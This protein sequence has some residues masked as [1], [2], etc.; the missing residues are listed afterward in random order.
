MVSGPQW[1]GQKNSTPTTISTL[2]TANKLDAYT[3][4]GEASDTLNLPD[5]LGSIYLSTS[6]RLLKLDCTKFYEKPD[7]YENMKKL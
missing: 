3:A 7:V 2:K 6:G 1:L 4:L 5:Y